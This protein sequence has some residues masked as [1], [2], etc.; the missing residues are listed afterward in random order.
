MLTGIGL[1]IILKQIP[2]ALGW[3]K[4]AF[5]DSSFFQLDGENTF[6][7]IFKAIDSIAPGAFLIASISMAILILWEAIL[8]KKYKV[9]RIINGPLV[10]V[11]V[12][13]FMNYLHQKGILNFSFGCRTSSEYSSSR[14]FRRIC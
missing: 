2:H 10:V 13:I 5:G 9:F 6:S 1:L 14:K 4:D 7:E 8:T 12:G 11:I 3:D